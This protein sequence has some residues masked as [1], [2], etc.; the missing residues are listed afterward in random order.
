[1]LDKPT[2]S[3]DLK[4]WFIQQCGMDTKTV[5]ERA[6][7]LTKLSRDLAIHHSTVYG[8]KRVPAHHVLKVSNLTGISPHELRPD[9]FPSSAAR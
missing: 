5:I 8:W 6:G 1:M 9:V 7:G 3:L 4:C 2:F